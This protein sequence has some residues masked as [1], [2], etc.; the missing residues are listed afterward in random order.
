MRVRSGEEQCVEG[1]SEETAK[2]AFEYAVK[3][4]PKKKFLHHRRDR[5]RENDDHDALLDRA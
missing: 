2:I 1:D 5:H 3:E 4:E